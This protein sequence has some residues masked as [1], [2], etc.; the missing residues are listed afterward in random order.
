VLRAMSGKNWQRLHRAVYLAGIAAIVHY[1][2]LVKAGVRTPWKVTEV[3][4]VFLLASVVYL[5]MKLSAKARAAA[6]AAN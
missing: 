5:G 4:A 6:A 3:L 1:W 2:W